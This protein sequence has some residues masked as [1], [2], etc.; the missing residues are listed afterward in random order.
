[1]KEILIVDDEL[2][3]RIFMATLFETSGYKPV[4]TKDGAE[5][6]QRARERTPSLIILDIMMP[7]EGGVQMYRQLKADDTLK[8]VPVIMLSAVSGE[9][10]FHSLKMLNA[11]QGEAL[12]EPNAYMEKPPEANELLNVA[13]KLLKDSKR[14]QT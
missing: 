4:V 6:I 11:A 13:Q 5:G 14:Q 9:T 12:P 2:H 7:G 10:F 8:K 3:M 1:M